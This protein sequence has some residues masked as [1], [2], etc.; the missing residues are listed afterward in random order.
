M[1]KALVVKAAD[2]SANRLARVSLGDIDYCT[3]ITLDK[4]EITSMELNVTETLT[5]TVSPFGCVETV[6]WKSSNDAVA[7]VHDGIVTF[8]GLGTA[9]ISATCGEYVATCSVI[10]DNVVLDSG[11]TFA[12][13]NNADG[14]DYAKFAAPSTYDKLTYADIV[15]LDSDRLRLTYDVSTVDYF[16]APMVMPNGVSKVTVKANQLKSLYSCYIFFFASKEVSSLAKLAKMIQKIRHDATNNMVNY[17]V[18]VPEG[19]DSIVVM[20]DALATYADSGDADAAA[21]S[22]GFEIVY[23]TA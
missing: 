10:V 14:T 2:F 19:A 22:I 23:K 3:G 5:A 9:T 4:N 1:A 7:T 11:A 8:V 13:I 18:D 15:P 6:F 21:K 20:V 17:T 12:F 16:I